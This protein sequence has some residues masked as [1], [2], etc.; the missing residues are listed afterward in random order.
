[1]NWETDNVI[2][3]NY[4]YGKG[5]MIINLDKIFYLEKKYKL[6]PKEKA[7][8]VRYST[9]DRVK[10][11]LCLLKEWEWC[12]EEAYE[13]TIQYLKSDLKKWYEKCKFYA[14]NVVNETPGCSKYKSFMSNYNNA[15]SKFK[16]FNNS[17]NLL[18]NTKYSLQDRVKAF[19]EEERKS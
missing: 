12:N 14:E 15:E 1:M 13:T 11:I 7:D 17:L 4:N 19:K 6:T 8:T 3:I 10:K 18:E 5:H 16:L 2:K 9:W